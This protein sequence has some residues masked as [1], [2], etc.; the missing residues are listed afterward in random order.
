[1]AGD[2]LGVDWVRLDPGPGV[3]LIVARSLEGRLQVADLHLEPLACPR[4][5]GDRPER[6]ER[7]GLLL[8]LEGCSVTLGGSASGG[9]FPMSPSSC[10]PRRSIWPTC[11]CSAA[12]SASA[13]A[14]S[15][16][17][18]PS[19]CW[20][21]SASALLE[22]L[23]HLRAAPQTPV[24][25]YVAEPGLHPVAA[26]EPPRDERED[27]ADTGDRPTEKQRPRAEIDRREHGQQERPNREQQAD[28]D[29][30]EG[31]PRQRPPRRLRRDLEGDLD[32][33]GE[34]RL[35][36]ADPRVELA[37]PADDLVEDRERVRRWVRGVEL[38]EL[39]GD[40]DGRPVA[41]EPLLGGDALGRE[42]LG[43]A[44]LLEH[45]PA[46]DQVCSVSARRSFAPE[47]VS[48]SRSSWARASSPCSTNPRSRATWSSTALIRPGF[49]GPWVFSSK[50]AFSRR[51]RA[52]DVPRSA[53][54]IDA[55]RRSRSV[56]SSRSRSASSWWRIDAV[57]RKNASLGMPVSSA[58]AW[59]ASVGSVMT[60]PS[61]SSRTVPFWPRNA[62]STE[63]GF[64]PPPLSSSSTSNSMR[65]D[66][67]RLLGRVPRAERVHL[68]AAGRRL[69]GQDELE[70]ALDRGLAGLVGAVDDRQA[71]APAGPRTRG[72]GGSRGR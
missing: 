15:S 23:L 40:L 10:A 26:P 7:V 33:A 58:S 59:S 41:L 50:I 45:G 37:Q 61:I 16:S 29:E 64:G 54:L 25:L 48:R 19:S 28:R 68:R 24:D 36:L 1:M 56:A 51:R 32:L 5:A 67:P 4:L 14:R 57:E 46:L 52:L 9:S 49:L 66:R 62:F 27:E 30:A 31:D 34:R 13:A 2:R 21:L 60:W 71:R 63:P 20:R 8:D 70:R 53:P 17:P 43:L 47:S 18:M 44:G 35:Q 12:R 72:S 38:R 6:V 22:L 42:A 69:A 55:W 11:S 3:R 65:D 39:V